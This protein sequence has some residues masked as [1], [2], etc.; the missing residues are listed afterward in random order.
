VADSGRL[1]RIVIRA[2]EKPDY[3]GKEV[4]SFTAFVNPAELT[5]AYEFEW[6]SAQGQGTTNSR[7]NFKKVKPSDLSISFF[8]DGTG[9]DGRTVDVREQVTK[10]QSVT[11]YSGNIHRPYYLLIA[12]G[13]LEVK[14]CVLKSASVTYK[15]FRPNGVPLRAVIAATF[16]D[17]SDDQTRVA[18]AQDQSP[19]LTHVRLVKA[20]DSLPALCNEIYGDPFRYL[21]VAAVNG[22]VDFRRLEPG[23]RIAFPPVER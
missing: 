8:I 6:D 17:N 21:Q 18:L 1:E 15:L 11:G 12:W 4:D 3:S 19:D 22:L 20:G 9:A 13:T 10:F 14:R 7:M 16:S 5:V 23:S 2:F